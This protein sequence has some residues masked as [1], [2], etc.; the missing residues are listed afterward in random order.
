[1]TGR[2]RERERERDNMLHLCPHWNSSVGC[3]P[4]AEYT[5]RNICASDQ[6]L[7]GRSEN[8]GGPEG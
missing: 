3:V 7:K 1:M 2:E 4:E 6:Q 5:C 8:Q